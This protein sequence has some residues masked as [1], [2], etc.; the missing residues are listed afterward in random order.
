MQGVLHGEALARDPFL[1][2]YGHWIVIGFTVLFALFLIGM[3]VAGQV[4][5]KSFVLKSISDVLQFLGEGIGLYFCIR[6]AI[7]MRV[8]AK[9]LSR[10][11]LAT[12]HNLRDGVAVTRM[13]AQMARR[14]ALAWIILAI[15]VALYASGQAVW[16]S[17]DIRMPSAQV[18]FPGLYDIGFVGSYPFFLIGTLLLT[19]RNHAAVGRTRL[20]MDALS[21]IGASLALSWFFVLNPTIAGLTQAPSPGAAFLSIYFPAGDLFLVAIGAFLMFSP[22]A[23][24][25]QQPVFLRL[26]VGLFLLAV[27]DSLLGYLSLSPGG[28]N[29]GTLQDILWPLS[30]MMVGLAAIEYPRSVA[31]EQEQSAQAS[32]VVLNTVSSVSSNRLSQFSLAAQTVAPFVLALF[33]AAILLII[34]PNMGGKSLIIEA[35]VIALALFVLVIVRQALT[36]FENNQLT[37]QMRG[38]L[39]VSR[40]ELKETR[41]EA[42]EATRALQTRRELEQGIASLQRV[43]A[44]VARGNFAVRAPTDAG[45]LLP[46]AQSLNLMLDRLSSLTQRAAAYDQIASEMRMLQLMVENL[47]QGQPLWTHKPPTQVSLLSK[48]VLNALIYLQRSQD[49]LKQR[50]ISVATTLIEYNRRADEALS[51]LEGSVHMQQLAIK[52]DERLSID[53]VRRLLQQEAIQLT[54]LSNQNLQSLNAPEQ[55]ARPAARPNNDMSRKSFTPRQEQQPP[56]RE[57]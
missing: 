17:Y 29:T 15:A 50:I 33:T 14:T 54:L 45:P 16:T 22:L 28:F 27:T 47:M 53:R 1:E 44:E 51:A 32:N 34:V 35:D 40:R 5:G 48:P 43:H 41:R 3:N 18:P 9:E 38:A 57:W 13:E 11:A 19:R 56:P 46:I 52:A 37:L 36:L 42:D 4:P 6:I 20:I 55:E 7:K 26:C 31:R 12:E 21:V 2:R 24:P 25:Q 30:M 23:N 39:A 10:K 49:A 8:A